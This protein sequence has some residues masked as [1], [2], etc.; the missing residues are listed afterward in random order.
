LPDEHT[1]APWIRQEQ[2]IA[3]LA[4]R[5]NSAELPEVVRRVDAFGRWWR[6]RREAGYNPGYVTEVQSYDGHVTQYLYEASNAA[7]PLGE[8]FRPLVWQQVDL[9]GAATLYDYDSWG[10]IKRQTGP[11]PNTMTEWTYHGE[12]PLFG[13]VAS[14]AVTGIDPVDGSTFV[15][16]TTYELM[17]S[18][19][20]LVVR[21]SEGTGNGGLIETST[22]LSPAG[23][24]LAATDG[25]GVTQRVMRSGG[26]ELYAQEAA[27][28]ATV[29]LGVVSYS[30]TGR[31]LSATDAGGATTQIGYRWDG[32]VEQITRPDGTIE[33]FEFDHF[34][35]ARGGTHASGE[36][37][38][39]SV[40]TRVDRDHACGLTTGLAE[41]VGDGMV[42]P[43]W[44]FHH[45][46]NDCGVPTT[47]GPTESDGCSIGECSYMSPGYYPCSLCPYQ[48]GTCE[49]WWIECDNGHTYR[50]RIRSCGRCGE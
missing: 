49:E 46:A 30:P 24:V 32:Q 11:I 37:S 39:Q 10:R 23:H 13:T 20:N 17:A 45:L 41:S 15:Q 36:A 12:G 1:D 27:D 4:I 7:D 5:I 3:A 8:R 31:L 16:T 38:D 14:E 25:A 47:P 29:Q 43:A 18:S 22:T 2:V 35:R 21:R 50:S 33:G 6:Y 26:V 34:G 44:E 40:Q 42:E 9:G 19:P 28:G 48:P